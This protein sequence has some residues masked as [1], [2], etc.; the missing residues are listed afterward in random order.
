VRLVAD[1]DDRRFAVRQAAERELEKLADQAEPV[2]RDALAGR[3]TLEALLERLDQAASP[4]RLRALR[5]V[6][7]LEW[8]GTPEA[9]QVL[10]GLVARPPE[11]RLSREASAALGQLSGGA[12]GA[13]L[14]AARPGREQFVCGAPRSSALIG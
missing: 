7:V 4:E 14:T 12:P 3:L 6:E 11:T 5:A 2:L 13:P 1:L 9:R 8:I 10:Q